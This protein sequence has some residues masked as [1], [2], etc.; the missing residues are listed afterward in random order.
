[1]RQ[2]P[3]IWRG[4]FVTISSIEHTCNG[5]LLN[6]RVQM[7]VALSLIVRLVPDPLVDEALIDAAAGASAD[8][9]MSQAV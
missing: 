5:L 3:P 9:T 6:A 7:P 8:E 1:M 4:L 2:T